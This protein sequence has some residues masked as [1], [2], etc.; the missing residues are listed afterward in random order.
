MIPIKYFWANR[1]PATGEIQ[2]ALELARKE[3]CVVII[4]WEMFKYPYSMIVHSNM[5]FEECEQQI[6]TVYGL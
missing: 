1:S 4:K 6:P 3:N 5:S 2:E